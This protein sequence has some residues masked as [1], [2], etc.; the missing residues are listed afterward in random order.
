MVSICRGCLG[1][2]CVPSD[3]L[4]SMTGGRYRS[5]IQLAHN[6]R[7]CAGDAGEPVPARH[8]TKLRACQFRA[9]RSVIIAAETPVEQRLIAR[10]RLNISASII[11][12]TIRNDR[13]G[14]S[15]GAQA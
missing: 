12:V 9:K 11:G 15:S 13:P 4:A 10:G 5:V 14:R 6:S 8:G 1:R 2:D 7:S 3:R